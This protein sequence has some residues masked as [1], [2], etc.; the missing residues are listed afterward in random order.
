[1]LPKTDLYHAHWLLTRDSVTEYHNDALW[2]RIIGDQAPGP[3]QSEFPLAM[4]ELGAQLPITKDFAITPGG[5]VATLQVARDRLAGCSFWPLRFAVG[6]VATLQAARD[7]LAGCS[8]WPLRF[9]VYSS[10]GNL[11]RK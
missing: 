3:R 6:S 4:E 2:I 9:A 10:G 5:S 7:K 8:F 1:L 11:N